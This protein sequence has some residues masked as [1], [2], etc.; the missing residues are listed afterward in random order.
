MICGICI[1]NGRR[2]HKEHNFKE[3]YTRLVRVEGLILTNVNPTEKTRNPTA[4][5]WAI[6]PCMRTPID[7]EE[8]ISGMRFPLMAWLKA[9][10]RRISPK[11]IR[12][13]M[14]NK[15]SG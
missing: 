6:C 3:N 11:R 7:T 2:I 8:R 1:Y 10:L 4:V 5:G 15:P 13:N 12:Q 14:K 9:T